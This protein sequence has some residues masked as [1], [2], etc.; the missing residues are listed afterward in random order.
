MADRCSTIAAGT[1]TPT[2]SDVMMAMSP[3]GTEALDDPSADPALVRRMLDD[4]A[5]ANRWF[6]GR[7]TVQRGL[8]ALFDAAPAQPTWTLLDIGTG[9]G[10]LP[11]AAVR[12]G[13]RRGIT[14][15]PLGL[16][17]IPA[18]ARLAVRHGVPTVLGCGSALPV[19][20]RSVDVALVSQVA[21]H[22][23]DDAVVRLFAE[24]HRVARR[25]VIIAD[26]RPSRTAELAFR[27]GGRLLGLHPVT[28]GDGITSLRRGFTPARLRALAIR[29][30]D[31]RVHVSRDLFSRILAWWR[32]DA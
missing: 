10:D 12:W 2:P 23:D 27:V 1:R 29:A 18:A 20:S 21:H 25:G 19:A 16:E 22:L 3:I 28:V 5:R 14:L 31:A 32:T 8:A 30:H 24:C 13:A 11:L 4:I 15:R 17:R 7:R 6:G 9:A 26:L